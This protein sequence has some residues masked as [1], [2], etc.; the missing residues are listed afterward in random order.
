MQLNEL[1]NN[2][3]V[4]YTADDSQLRTLVLSR[5]CGALAPQVH[6]LSDVSRAD[7]DAVSQRH[8]SGG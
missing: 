6:L 8:V 5:L 3:Y 4:I 1:K 7:A 2:L